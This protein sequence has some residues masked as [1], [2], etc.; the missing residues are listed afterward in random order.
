MSDQPN[1]DRMRKL[2]ALAQRGVG[3]ERENA[4]RML[5]R[6]LAKYGMTIDDLTGDDK[7]EWRTFTVSCKDE[8]MLLI[9]VVT[10]V[11]NVNSYTSRNRRNLRLIELTRAQFIEIQCLMSVYWPA[12]KRHMA[13]ARSAFL[14]SNRIW[15]ENP[16]DDG[17][18]AKGSGMPE[19]DREAILAMAAA[20]QATPVHK[21]LTGGVQ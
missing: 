21:Q 6:M 17:D 8:S 5:S 7:P 20:T 15:P 1:L 9:N 16:P 11:L 10:K 14:I 2:L 18:D 19:E 13:H 3:G 12:L 4:D